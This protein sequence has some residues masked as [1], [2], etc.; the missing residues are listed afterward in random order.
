MMMMRRRIADELLEYKIRGQRSIYSEGNRGVD[1][2]KLADHSEQGC[3]NRE[4]NSA[5]A[6]LRPVCED[7]IL[8]ISRQLQDQRYL[9]GI[10]CSTGA[11]TK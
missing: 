2:V 11:K 6:D 3:T 5:S 4:S 8:V 10:K 1:L 9:I 7:K